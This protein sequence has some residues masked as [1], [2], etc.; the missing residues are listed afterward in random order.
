MPYLYVYLYAFYLYV[1]WLLCVSCKKE[2][3]HIEPTSTLLNGIMIIQA[4]KVLS[5]PKAT[6]LFE[7]LGGVA[8]GEGEGVGCG[9]MD[10][11]PPLLIGGGCKGG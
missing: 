9:G 11:C 2:T 8:Q 7:L 5:H 1:Y 6:F 4:T 10:S 3:T